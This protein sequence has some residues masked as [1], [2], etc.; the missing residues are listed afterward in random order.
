M[1]LSIDNNIIEVMKWKNS[2]LHISINGETVKINILKINKLSAKIKIGKK[3]V[4]FFW[5]QIN[6]NLFQ[7]VVEGK[8]FISEIK[9]VLPEKSI[10]RTLQKNT[11][12]EIKAPVSGLISK[13]FI[14]QKG[15]IY[16]GQKLLSLNAMKM[17]NEIHAP[18]D[19]TVKELK[20][21]ENKE[22]NKND[23]LL[24]IIPN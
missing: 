21:V 11:I 12:Y 20:I 19:G 14:S 6:N 8:S 24:T 4:D 18:I 7:I 10:D 22:V 5:T 16:K 2:T 15:K 17:E 23:T 9:Y 13:I 3:K 1:K